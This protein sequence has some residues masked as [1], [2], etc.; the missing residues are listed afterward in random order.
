MP[1]PSNEQPSRKELQ[2]SWEVTVGFLETARREIGLDG[3]R[4]QQERP[5]TT[6][7]PEA[8]HWDFTPKRLERLA[9]YEEYLAHNE[10]ELALDELEQIGEEGVRSISYWQNLLAAADNMGLA[11][12]AVRYRRKLN[13]LRG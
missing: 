8:V 13:E 2:R 5:F 3:G 1:R 9:E 6:G 11:K 7:S 10:L 4:H 12:H